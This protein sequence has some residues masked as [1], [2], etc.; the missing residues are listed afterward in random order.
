LHRDGTVH[1]TSFRG[2]ALGDE[3]GQPTRLVG[4]FMDITERK[5]REEAL[6]QSE[7]RL[8]LMLDRMPAVLWT[9]DRELRVSFCA[10]AGMA[11]LNVTPEQWIGRTLYEY[12]GTED[13]TF[14]PIAAHD[15]ALAGESI[16]YE[17][18][19]QSH[20]FRTHLQPLRDAA[21]QIAG[22]I[23]VTLDVTAH[24]RAEA[25]RGELD[26]RIAQAQK[27]ETLG[28][29]AGGLAHDFNNLLT[30]VLG[31]V[32]LAL[33]DLP[34][35]SSARSPLQQVEEAAL[36]AADLTR[37]L[38]AYSGRGKFVV[39]PVDLSRLIEDMAALLKSVASRKAQ[40]R[41]ELTPNLPAVQA[42]AEQLRQVILNLFTNASEALGDKHGSL[43]VRTGVMHADRAYLATMHVNEDLPPGYYAF[44]EISDTGCGMDEATLKRL[45]DPFFSTKFTGRGLGLAAVLGIVRGHR[46][47]IKVASEPGRGSAFKVLLPC[48]DL[49]H[50]EAS[51]SSPSPRWRSSGTILLMDDEEAVRQVVQRA[52]ESAGFRVLAASDGPEGIDLFR[53]HSHEVV[54]VVLD[55][56]MPRAS[57]E[58]VFRALRL[59]RPDVRVVLLSGFNEPEVANLFAEKGLAGFVQKPFRVDDLL[60]VLRRTLDPLAG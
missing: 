56:T 3:A 30:G 14:Y 21:G 39:A 32:S 10:G 54:A 6:R 60:A 33:M 34:P 8:R 24:R 1:W 38:L 19:C 59:L 4:V 49:A 25:G 47:A 13:R 46:G 43:G 52:L 51:T 29:L 5:E 12:L 44:V 57:G 7:Q 37:Q 45:F 40:L 31:N 11:V 55:L 41:F 26:A 42:D 22:C 2:K 35:E 36:R 16:S 17:M 58:E 18:E 9:T 28:T 27:L 23:G 20:I 50:G 53:R 15:R 48:V